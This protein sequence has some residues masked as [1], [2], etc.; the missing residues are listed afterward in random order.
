LRVS[1]GLREP[2]LDA[3]RDR[4]QHGHDQDPDPERLG[5]HVLEVLT[6][7]T[8]QVLCLL[9]PALSSASIPLTVR[10]NTSCSDGS[11]RSKRRHRQLVDEQREDALRVGAGVEE[12]LGVLARVVSGG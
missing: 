8:S 6:L 11:L 1:L 7:A 5:P 3:D 9:T 12:Q 4:D 2:L 10:T